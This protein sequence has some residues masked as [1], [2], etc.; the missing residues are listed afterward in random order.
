M[1]ILPGGKMKGEAINIR[2]SLEGFLA[3]KTHVEDLRPMEKDAREEI[4]MED[5]TFQ[6]DPFIYD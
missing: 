5:I 6:E 3:G 4:N 1:D 2:K